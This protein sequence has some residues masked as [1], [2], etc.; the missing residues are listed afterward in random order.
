MEDL[1]T[2]TISEA[3][4]TLPLIR[5]IVKDIREVWRKLSEDQLSYDLL[6]GHR[7]LDEFF[8]AEIERLKEYECKLDEYITELKQIGVSLKSPELGL[9]DFLYELNGRKVCL[10]WKDGE[11]D[12]L[13]W[14]STNAGYLNRQLIDQIAS[15]V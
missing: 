2:F 12:I 14:H 3:R 10:C 9:I 6:N 7:N 1:K 13:Y 15:E 11:D 4:A 8:P 5:S